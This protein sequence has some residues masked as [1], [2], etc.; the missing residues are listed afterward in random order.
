MNR[1]CQ[2]FFRKIKFCTETS[3]SVTKG[4]D[5]RGHIVKGEKEGKRW[6]NNRRKKC[7]TSSLYPKL[8]ANGVASGLLCI[9]W[10]FDYIKGRP[11]SPYSSSI[12]L[13][14]KMSTMTIAAP[15]TFAVVLNNLKD[16]NFW[17]NIQPNLRFFCHSGCWGNAGLDGRKPHENTKSRRLRI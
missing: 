1:H 10:V 9:V 3:P 4:T 12:R 14:E 16:I 2:A 5:E 11:Y 6:F 17:L 15:T 13:H 7:W 8:L